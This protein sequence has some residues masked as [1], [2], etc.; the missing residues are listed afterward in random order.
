MRFWDLQWRG[1]EA[2]AVF[3]ISGEVKMWDFGWLWGFGRLS[4]GVLVPVRVYRF[5]RT[6]IWFLWDDRK[7]FILRY[8]SGQRAIEDIFCTRDGGV[9]ADY[10]YNRIISL[11]LPFYQGQHKRTGCGPS[12]H[13]SAPNLPPSLVFASSFRAIDR[14]AN[15][16]PCEVTLRSSE[17]GDI[18]WPG[19]EDPLC[20]E[21]V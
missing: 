21:E 1:F 12:T 18:L 9:V 7:F 3:W 19:D 20:W 13:W 10:P 15:E 8:L 11:D 2:E 16:Y 14:F 17:W 6:G 5:N 4:Y